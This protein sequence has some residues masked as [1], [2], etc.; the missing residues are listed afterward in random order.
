M[1]PAEMAERIARLEAHRENSH[2]WLKDVS[3]RLKH[4]ER[5]VWYGVGVLTALQLL[6][7]FYKP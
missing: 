7:K 3:N 4:V 6:L 1:T 5:Q 2:D